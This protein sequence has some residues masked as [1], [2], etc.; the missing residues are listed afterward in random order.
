[1][2][3]FDRCKS[4]R[5]LLPRRFEYTTSSSVGPVPYCPTDD[6]VVYSKR[7][8]NKVL[9]DLPSIKSSHCDLRRT[10]RSKI[11]TFLIM[12]VQKK[13]LLENCIYRERKRR[14]WRD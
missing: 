3:G 7:L 14:R 11:Q 5:T 9:V 4:A 8:G 6:E 1:M 12:R 10:R 2:R 13:I